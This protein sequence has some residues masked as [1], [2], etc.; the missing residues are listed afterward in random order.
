MIYLKKIIIETILECITVGSNMRW[1][2]NDNFYWLSIK[3]DAG[4]LS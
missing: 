4:S 2:K 1:I 3:G